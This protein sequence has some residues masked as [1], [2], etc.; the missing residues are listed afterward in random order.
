MA[1]RS[2]RRPR[3]LRD[4]LSLC[5]RGVR[6]C[7]W[8]KGPRHTKSRRAL[9]SWEPLIVAGG[10]PLRVDVVQDLSDGLVAQGDDFGTKGASLTTQHFTSRTV[11]AE[12]YCGKC[13]KRTQHRIDDHRKGPCLDCIARLELQ[14]NQPKPEERQ[15]FL[16]SVSG[17]GAA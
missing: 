1:G 16:F 13:Q 4:V 14:H 6:V 10:R 8:F 7:A 2:P 15:R 5:P 11:S 12:F 9:V 3:P 17:V